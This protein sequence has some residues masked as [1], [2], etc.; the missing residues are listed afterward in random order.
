MFEFV[1]TQDIDIGALV[2]CSILQR[3]AVCRTHEQT[4]TRC[5]ARQHVDRHRQRRVQPQH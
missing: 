4:A 5:N 1:N 3:V 2:C